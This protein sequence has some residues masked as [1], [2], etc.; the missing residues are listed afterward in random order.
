METIQWR[1]I[2]NKAET[3]VFGFVFEKFKKYLINAIKF[4]VKTLNYIPH[5]GYSV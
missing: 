5:I 1:D 4:Y 3:G 2:L